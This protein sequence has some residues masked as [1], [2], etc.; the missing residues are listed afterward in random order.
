MDALLA[1]ARIKKR[2]DGRKSQMAFWF[3]TL[4]DKLGLRGDGG[5][6]PDSSDRQGED[7]ETSG[8]VTK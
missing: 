4:E 8:N 1:L 2:V 7:F 3:S 6:D 5:T